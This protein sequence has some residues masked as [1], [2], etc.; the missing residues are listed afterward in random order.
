MAPLGIQAA[1]ASN[2]GRC[3]GSRCDRSTGIG[4]FYLTQE[5]RAVEQ[6]WHRYGNGNAR[7]LANHRLGA[8]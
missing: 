6:S 2:G 7:G 3:E 5:L 1:M 4:V 8:R